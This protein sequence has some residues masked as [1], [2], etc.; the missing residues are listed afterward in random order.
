MLDRF[1]RA[2]LYRCLV[3]FLSLK[4]GKSCWGLNTRSEGHLLSFPTPPQTHVADTHSHGYGHFGTATR[5]ISGLLKNWVIGL[6]PLARL[7]TTVRLRLFKL[8]I[9]LG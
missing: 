5:G 2:W 7:H 9:K 1:W 3:S 8:V 6:E 4:V